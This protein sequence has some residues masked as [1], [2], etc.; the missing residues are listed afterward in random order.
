MTNVSFIYEYEELKIL[1]DFHP[2]IWLF[3]W[4]VTHARSY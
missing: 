4:S 1:D 3:P 2:K